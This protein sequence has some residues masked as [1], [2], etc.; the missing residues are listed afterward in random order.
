[1]LNLA[2]FFEMMKNENDSLELM[3]RWPSD[4]VPNTPHELASR[5]LLLFKDN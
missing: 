2:Q 1:M 3:E 4:L 5:I